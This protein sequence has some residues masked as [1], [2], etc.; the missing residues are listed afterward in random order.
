MIIILFIYN[1]T[2][3]YNNIYL[4]LSKLKNYIYFIYLKKIQQIHNMRTKTRSYKQTSSH[5]TKS[6]DL[7]EKAL[8]NKKL[9]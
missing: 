6:T 8:K 1:S 9:L 7:L 4:K 3:Q 2:N 5:A